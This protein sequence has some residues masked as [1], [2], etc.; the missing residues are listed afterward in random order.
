MLA[1]Q[2]GG[3]SSP[4]GQSAVM[5]NVAGQAINSA[6]QTARLKYELE[7]LKQ[8]TRKTTADADI[9]EDIRDT[10]RLV[11]PHDLGQFTPDRG[12]FAGQRTTTTRAAEHFNQI[13]SISA[14]ASSARATALLNALAAPAAS[15]A[16]TRAAGYYKTYIQD[17]LRIILGIGAARAIRR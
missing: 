5:Q 14:N 4:T 2:L 17:I 16:G 10:G 6:T 15:V 1:F 7:N 11:V 8:L 3:A 12:R 13:E 9:S